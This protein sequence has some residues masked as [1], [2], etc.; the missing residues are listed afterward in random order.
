MEKI[1]EI[2]GLKK[3]FGK[4]QALSDV[5]FDV[6]KGEIVG[7]IGPNGSGKSTTIRI[8]LG[9]IKADE[10]RASI[11]GQD[12]W[13]E[14]VDI[15]KRVAYVPGDV[16]L[17][18]NLTGGEVIDLFLSMRGQKVDKQRKEELIKKFE[19]NPTK[20]C[21]SYSTGNRQK[22]A[23][24]AAFAAD[25]DVYIFDEPTAGL[26]PL[27]ERIF[28]EQAREVQQRGA[29]VLLSSHILSEVEQLC[30]TVAIIRQGEIVE[31]GS[32]NELRHLTRTQIVMKT[33]EKVPSLE[34]QDF[35]HDVS[36]EKGEI[37]FQLD[38]DKM[39]EF[40]HFIAPY[41][42]TKLESAPPKLEDLFMRHYESTKGG[43]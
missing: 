1:I 10:G 23:L 11:F 13:D 5:S 25:A 28:Q 40:L 14:A 18:P 2:R 42:V 32:M 7:F 12:V 39:P 24:I 34:E 27:Q 33:N 41:H 30:D 31:A 8:L 26:D 6:S 35:A 17:W 38:S 37:I 9:L 22:V 21:R 3:A 15:H 36:R 4:T 20:K 43:V 16:S 19:F 29:S